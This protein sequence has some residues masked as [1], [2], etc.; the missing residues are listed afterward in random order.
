VAVNS[1]IQIITAPRAVPHPQMSGRGTAHGTVD[2]FAN[3]FVNNYPQVSWYQK[4]HSP[5][6][7]D[8]HG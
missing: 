1:I 8:A 3:H 5:T 6:H 7:G 2:I 4:K